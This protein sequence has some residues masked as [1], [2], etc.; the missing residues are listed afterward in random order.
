MNHAK[1]APLIK[2]ILNPNLEKIDGL[3]DLS[4]QEIVE[5]IKNYMPDDIVLGLAMKNADPKK[6]Y[7]FVLNPRAFGILQDKGQ[8][9]SEVMPALLNRFIEVQKNTSD[10]GKYRNC[11]SGTGFD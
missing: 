1:F 8:R 10:W 3:E 9:M 7:G 2:A 4:T 11:R 6:G 5:Y